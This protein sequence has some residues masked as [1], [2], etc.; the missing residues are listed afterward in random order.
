MSKRTRTM[1]FKVERTRIPKGT[2]KRIKTKNFKK[3]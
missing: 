2:S 1:N 3:E